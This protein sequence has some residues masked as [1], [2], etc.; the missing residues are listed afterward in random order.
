MGRV[1]RKGRG[2]VGSMRAEG[3]DS[4]SVCPMEQ[5]RRHGAWPVRGWVPDMQGFSGRDPGLSH[6]VGS[7]GDAVAGANAAF[8]IL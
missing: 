1:W 4:L 2:A 8:A 6:L 5:G 7:C 3:T